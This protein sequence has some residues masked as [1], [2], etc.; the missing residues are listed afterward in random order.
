[1][2]APLDNSAWQ[3]EAYYFIAKHE[4]GKISHAS[5]F[6]YPTGSKSNR[7]RALQLLQS[8][9]FMRSILECAKCKSWIEDNLNV[10]FFKMNVTP[11]MKKS[12][13][14]ISRFRKIV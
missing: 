1:M 6:F 3:H 9:A 8:R 10:S 5:V 4:I 11:S 13:K 12:D 14:F 2:I 7:S